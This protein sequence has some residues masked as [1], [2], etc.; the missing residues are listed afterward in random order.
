MSFGSMTK[1]LGG[2]QQALVLALMLISVFALFYVEMGLM[3]KIGVGAL[4]FGIVFLSTLAT[5]IM[6]QEKDARRSKQ[7]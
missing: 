4:V 6:R 1:N 7:A 3:Y 2:V 5:T